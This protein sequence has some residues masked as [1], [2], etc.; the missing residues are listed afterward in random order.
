M[1]QVEHASRDRPEK[2][3]RPGKSGRPLFRPEAVEHHARGLVV[4]QRK[5]DLTDKTT[6]RA[7]R[8]LLL[9]FAAALAAA[10]TIQA[11]ES[12]RG[13]AQV[14]GRQATIMLPIGALPRLEA[15]QLVRV[16]VGDG[17]VQ[18]RVLS[19]NRPVAGPPAAVP[20]LA[21]LDAEVPQGEEVDAVVRLD[22]HSIV[23]MLLPRLKSMFGRSSG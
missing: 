12:A 10:F 9:L 8:L 19:I 16:R 15:G 5:L 6:T 23:A 13:A 14:G 4:G 11:D 22:R 3:D 7:F 21:V 17:W 1:S 18:G 20:V 2:G